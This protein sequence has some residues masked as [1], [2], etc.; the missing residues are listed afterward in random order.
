M[1]LGQGLAVLL[2]GGCAPAWYCEG[3][4]RRKCAALTAGWGSH[5]LSMFPPLNWI[6]TQSSPE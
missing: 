3:A 2:L 5:L 6:L 1:V 4:L